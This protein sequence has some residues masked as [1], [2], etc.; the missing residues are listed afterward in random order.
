MKNIT[1]RKKKLSLVVKKGKHYRR[2]SFPSLSVDELSLDSS[3]SSY[4]VPIKSF[5][6]PT[7]DSEIYKTDS[8]RIL[9]G[10]RKLSITKLDVIEESSKTDDVGHCN[11]V[12]SNDSLVIEIGTG[13]SSI[14]SLP[15]SPELSVVENL[16]I[17]REMLQ[18]ISHPTINEHQAN[19]SV[20]SNLYNQYLIADV[21]ISVPLMQQDCELIDKPKQK[22][23]KKV[24]KPKAPAKSPIKVSDLLNKVS[25]ANLSLNNTLSDTLDQRLCNLLLESAKKMTNTSKEN[26]M[27]VDEPTETKKGGKKRCS[28]PRKRI[29]KKAKATVGPVIDEHME[30]CA[31]AGR[32]SCPPLSTFVP[33]DENANNSAD[34]QLKPKKPARV[35]KDIIKVKIQRPIKAIEVTD[36]RNSSRASVYTDSGINESVSINGMFHGNDNVELIH[37]HSETCLQAHECIGNSIEFVEYSKSSVISIHSTESLQNELN[38]AMK[39]IEE[40]FEGQEAPMDLLECE[41]GKFKS[42]KSICFCKLRMNRRLQLLSRRRPA[43]DGRASS[44]PA[45]EQ[46]FV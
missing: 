36:D 28:T 39:D 31:K 46:M 25:S 12:F 11:A 13:S 37:N 7:L 43:Y 32:Q 26:L 33:L 10:G 38:E 8:Y 15:L 19:D 24:K 41:S 2:K 44:I 18:N 6:H 3:N 16:S 22:T 34:V 4:F 20:V 42:Q 5:S 9:M 35:K 14:V 1:K 23:A 30:S 45:A 21:D 29:T 17:S 27:E 40:S